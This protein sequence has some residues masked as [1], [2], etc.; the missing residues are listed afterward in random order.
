MNKIQRYI[1]KTRLAKPFSGVGMTRWGSA[2]AFSLSW[3]VP[4]FSVRLTRC[5]MTLLGLLGLNY[6]I[7]IW[8]RLRMND[9]VGIGGVAA[10][11]PFLLIWLEEPQATGSHF[12]IEFRLVRRGHVWSKS[13]L[14][15]LGIFKGTWDDTMDRFSDTQS[16]F[17]ILDSVVDDTRV[18]EIIDNGVSLFFFT[19]TCCLEVGCRNLHWDSWL[20]C[21]AGRSEGYRY[22]R[23]SKDVEIS[24]IEFLPFVVCIGM[25]KL[26]MM[27]WLRLIKILINKIDI[28]RF[29]HIFKW[30]FGECIRE[31]WKE[32]FVIECDEVKGSMKNGCQYTDA[33]RENLSWGDLQQSVYRSVSVRWDN[34][35]II[36]W[37]LFKM[38][39]SESRPTSTKKRS[40]LIESI[41]QG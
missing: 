2:I 29:V 5:C 23:W 22:E 37:A 19:I 25:I 6:L 26:G 9:S 14:G 10:S 21:K 13:V 12:N 36:I 1:I 33:W 16:A 3:L 38:A 41:N 32:V 35:I 11:M 20:V 34:K 7:L 27:I 15:T 30:I 8:W 17:W 18:V 31:E 24:R 28:I 4:V 39:N 40:I